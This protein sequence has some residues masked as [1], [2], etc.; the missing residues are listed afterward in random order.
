[1]YDASCVGGISTTGASVWARI[2]AAGA[3]GG[4]ALAVVSGAAGWGTAHRLLAGLT[5][6]PLAAL[7]VLAW[8]SARRLFPM[9][10]TALALFGLAALMT[11]STVHLALATAAFAATA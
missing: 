4:T 8:V 6:P 9:A 1:R 7:V 2:V 5:L 3:V 10:V 11:G